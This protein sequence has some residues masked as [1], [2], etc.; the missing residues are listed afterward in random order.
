M[1]LSSFGTLLF[2]IILL[3]KDRIFY[4]TIFFI[5][6][7]F[8]LFDESFFKVLCYIYWRI[9]KIRSFSESP[10]RLLSS[11][12]SDSTVRGDGAT[13]SEGTLLTE[14]YGAIRGSSGDIPVIK[15]CIQFSSQRDWRTVLWQL[16]FFCFLF[17]LLQFY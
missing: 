16:S 3:F 7:H 6:W 4:A 14:S 12:G 10:Q 9:H 2:E 1:I 11:Q 5:G 8:L 17:L 13:S 15:C